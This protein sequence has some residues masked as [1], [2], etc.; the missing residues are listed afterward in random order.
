[1]LSPQQL[2]MPPWCQA[3]MRRTSRSACRRPRPPGPL[4]TR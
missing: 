2:P 4:R 3:A 1:M